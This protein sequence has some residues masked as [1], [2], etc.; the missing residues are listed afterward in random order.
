MVKMVDNKLIKYIE[1]NY[2]IQN[3][4]INEKEKIES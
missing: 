3:N 1:V 2:K 4:R